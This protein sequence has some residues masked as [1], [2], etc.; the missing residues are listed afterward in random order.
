VH[1]LTAEDPFP[2]LDQSG[3]AALL[4]GSFV[5]IIKFFTSYSHVDFPAN[6]SSAVHQ[7]IGI[8]LFLAALAA[9]VGEVK[10]ASNGWR[11]TGG[12]Q[13]ITQHR[14]VSTVLCK[15]WLDYADR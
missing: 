14:R 13:S 6:A 11:F 15:R 12:K 9:L 10:L 4:A 7:Q 5:V 3:L 1:G 8:P 2:W